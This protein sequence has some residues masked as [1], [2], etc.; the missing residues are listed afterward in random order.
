MK[1][2]SI[3]FFNI[4]KFN[5]K[6]NRKKKMSIEKQHYWNC[7]QSFRKLSWMWHIINPTSNALKCKIYVLIKFNLRVLYWV[8]FYKKQ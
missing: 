2:N 3:L 8:Q 4:L 7:I 6:F 1:S 5:I